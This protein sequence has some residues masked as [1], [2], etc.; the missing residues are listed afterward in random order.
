[1]PKNSEGSEVQE[2][3]FE[4]EGIPV[5]YYRAGSGVPVLLLHGSGPG[6]SSIGNWRAVLEPLASRYEIFAMDLIGF[7]KS[8]RK[9]SPPYFDY[10]LWVRQAA[11]M[12]D[13]IPGERVGVIG[14]SLSASIALSLAAA[15]ERING[16]VTTGAMGASFT[17]TDATRRC[18]TCPTNREDL[19]RTLEG[20]IYDRNVI[21]EEYIAAREP[22]VFAS[23]YA[24]YF[25][26]M[27]EGEPGRYIESAVL[28]EE[29][30]A[31]VRCKVLMMHGREDSAFPPESSQR[32]ARCLPQADLV[33][34]A[35][36][37]HS[38]AFERTGAFL[39][40]AND[41]FSQFTGQKGD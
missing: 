17:P 37:S 7:G 31:R 16:V 22:V 27:F 40:L 41:F 25:N 32:I 6:A 34:L 26:S 4:F 12:L 3:K 29:T 11:A 38:V 21:T 20:L 18:W 8:G 14:H 5:N 19:K 9:P 36:C 28:S 23:G 35:R 39:S 10:S 24:E 2:L 13:R 33:L 1:M 30:L 15:D